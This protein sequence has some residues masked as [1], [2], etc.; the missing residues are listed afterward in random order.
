M[1]EINGSE[2]LFLFGNEWA[3]LWE[4]CCLMKERICD[5]AG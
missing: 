4:K 1:Q 2:G 5:S 3:L